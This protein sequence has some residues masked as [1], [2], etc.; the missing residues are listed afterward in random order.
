MFLSCKNCFKARGDHSIKDSL[1][2]L[3][4]S[5]GLMMVIKELDQLMVP[6]SFRPHFFTKLY[7]PSETPKS[8]KIQI[9]IGNCPLSNVSVVSGRPL[10]HIQTCI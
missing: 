3:A 2:K 10:P 5:S 1:P 8:T 9:F 6:I 4:T 7:L